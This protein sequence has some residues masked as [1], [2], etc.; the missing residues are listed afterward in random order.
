MAASEAVSRAS[1]L[2]TTKPRRPTTRPRRTKN[3]W[4]AASRSS[5]AKAAMSKSSGVEDTICW[6]SM[7][8]R[9]LPSWSRSRAAS[10]KLSSSAAWRIS[11]S[12]R[13]RVGRVRPSMKVTKSSTIRR[14]S[15]GVTLP[16]QGP[17]HL[18]MSNRMQG[19]PRRR[20]R[21]NTPWSRSAS[22]RCAEEI[23]GLPDRVGVGI[24]PEVLRPLA[25]GAPL[26]PRPGDLVGQGHGQPRVRLVVAVADVVAGPVLLDQVVLELE[27][28]D[29]GLD[30]HPLQRGRGLD[31]GRGAG[32]RFR[33]GWK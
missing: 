26:D 5:S 25:L 6:R 8:L 15:S 22:G 16:T 7:A 28:L 3:T 17:E 33:I 21:S 20:C 11:A 13:C 12:S 19:R 4:T 23:Q 31:H 27:G 14:C 18:L 32:C 1:T 2:S 10:S 24:G 30:E 29:L 9:T